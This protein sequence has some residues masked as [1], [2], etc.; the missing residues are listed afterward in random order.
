MRGWEWLVVVALIAAA[1]HAAVE[2]V[3][4]IEATPTFQMPRMEVAADKWC[5]AN[6]KLWK[7]RHT[8]IGDLCLQ[9][10]AP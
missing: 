1:L 9:D 6:G 7:A 4:P 8:F 10:D 3:G 2:A 5:A